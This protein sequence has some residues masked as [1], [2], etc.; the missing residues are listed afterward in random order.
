MRLRTIPVT[1]FSL[2]FFRGIGIAA[3]PPDPCVLPDAL[4]REI[5]RQYPG[6][7]VVELSDLEAED[8]TLFEGDHGKACPGLVKVDFYG[9][10]KPTLALVLIG[11]TAAP[12]DAELVIARQTDGKWKATLLET[13][14][15]SLPVVWSDSPGTYTDV[16]GNKKIRARR[17][18]IVFCGYG[19]WA[20]LYAWTSN[21]VEK[22]WLAD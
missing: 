1:V 15:S 7:K 22:I 10:R 14:K 18:V 12:N 17:P 21:K 16:Y 5:A 6:A 11:K 19:S 8:R 13:A 4:Q 9:D 2:L 3:P 20:I